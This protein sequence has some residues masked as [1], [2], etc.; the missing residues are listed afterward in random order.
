LLC[1]AKVAR[2][3]QQGQVLRFLGRLGQHPEKL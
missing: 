2:F 3:T 1:L